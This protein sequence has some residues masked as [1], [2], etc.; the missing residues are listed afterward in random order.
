MLSCLRAEHQKIMGMTHTHLH[1]DLHTCQWVNIILHME[2]EM[3]IF[4]GLIKRP[5]G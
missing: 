4:G 3:I 2:Y 1:T 5:N